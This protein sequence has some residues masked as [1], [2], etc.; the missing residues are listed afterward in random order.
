MYKVIVI[1]LPVVAFCHKMDESHSHNPTSFNWQFTGHGHSHEQVILPS[2]SFGQHASH[3]SGQNG[4]CV[5]AEKEGNI[6]VGGL[7]AI[8]VF[9]L[10][11]L[12]VG[13]CAGWTRRGREVS[14]EQVMLA[15]RD[16]GIFV[17]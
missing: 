12:V 13:A 1:L 17:G 2:L 7:S 9:Y 15:G 8:L 16:L 14:Q 6:W 11:I 10:V 5:Y 4:S 3:Q